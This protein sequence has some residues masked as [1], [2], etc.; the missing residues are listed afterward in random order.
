MIK[1]KIQ[2]IF[3]REKQREDTLTNR[4]MIFNTFEFESNVKV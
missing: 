1:K 2:K 3:A 4:D